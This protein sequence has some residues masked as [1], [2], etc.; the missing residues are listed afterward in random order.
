MGLGSMSWKH[1]SIWKLRI[2]KRPRYST[3]RSSISSRRR[4]RI[5]WSSLPFNPI[6]RSKIL[7]K[8][9]KLPSLLNVYVWDDLGFGYGEQKAQ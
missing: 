5:M 8:N 9:S 4:V 6:E 7:K 2:L 1:S 3:I